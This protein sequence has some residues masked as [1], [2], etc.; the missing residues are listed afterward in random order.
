[1]YM[2][3]SFFLQCMLIRTYQEFGDYDIHF[4][5]FHLVNVVFMKTTSSELDVFMQLLY[6]ILINLVTLQKPSRERELAH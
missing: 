6:S 4:V 2:I 1:M 5:F 3:D